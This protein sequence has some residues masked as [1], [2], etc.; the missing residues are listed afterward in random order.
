MN[1]MSISPTPR[2]EFWAGF[3]TTL[4]LV[5]GAIPFGIIFGAVAIANGLSPAAA[6]GMSA[7]VFAGSSQFV[8]ANMVAPPVPAPIPFVVLTTFVVNL[9]HALY[10]ATLAPYM[11]HL[12]QKWLLPLGFWLTDE[13]FVIVVQRYQQPDDSP[14]KHWYHFGSSVFMYV[15]WQLSTLVG[16]LAGQSIQD[17]GRWGLSFAMVVT[18]I[19]MLLPMLNTRPMLLAAVVAAASSVLLN[20][21]DNKLGLLLAA[22]LGVV[23]GVVAERWF[24]PEMTKAARKAAQ[25]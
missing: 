10:S 1:P 3:K 5:I 17:P 14:Y 11:K 2:A 6:L 20:G 12:S 13:T 18:F 25:S 7:F 19:G 9:R 23:A 24:T 21:L 8:A 16:I 22:L 15:N 4:P